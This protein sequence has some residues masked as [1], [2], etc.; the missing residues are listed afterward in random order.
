MARTRKRIKKMHFQKQARNCEPLEPL[1][2]ED[3]YIVKMSGYKKGL[4][5]QTNEK[6]PRFANSFA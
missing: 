2:E 4:I 6:I 1:S 5:G 3:K